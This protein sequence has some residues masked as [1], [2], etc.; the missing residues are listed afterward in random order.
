MGRLKLFRL[1]ISL[2][3]GCGALATSG[4]THVA[5][6]QTHTH[7]AERATIIENDGKD[8]VV[9]DADTGRVYRIPDSD[10]VDIQHPGSMEMVLGGILAVGGT[11]FAVAV[12]VDKG[13]TSCDNAGASSAQSVSCDQTDG[14]RGDVATALTGFAVL[15]MIAPGTGLFL[16]GNHARTDSVRRAQPKPKATVAPAPAARGVALTVQF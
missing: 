3:A 9:Q 1:L 11:A 13:S 14:M 10:V 5:T 16:W 6:I 12:N 7:F 8:L 2:F 4:C 15:T